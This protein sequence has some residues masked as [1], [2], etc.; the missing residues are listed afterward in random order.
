MRSS[1]Y[2]VRAG[3][4]ALAMTAIIAGRVAAM[5]P[6]EFRAS[7]LWATAH[8]SIATYI[9]FK[10]DVWECAKGTE[11]PDLFNPTTL[12]VDGYLDWV[13][14]IGAQGFLIT[15]MHVDGFCLWPS[16]SSPHNISASAWYREHG[17]RNVLREFLDGARKRGLRV[18]LYFSMQDRYFEAH[19]D[20]N[21]KSYTAAV[22][23]HLRELLGGDYGQID[24]LVLDAWP[25]LDAANYTNLPYD[26]IYPLIKKLQPNC[27]V[28]INHH[29]HDG[30]HGDVD[31][32]EQPAKIDGEPPPGRTTFP[33]VLCWSTLHQDGVWFGHS[34]L[35][36]H[37]ISQAEVIRARTERMT[38]AGY[39]SLV[40][41]SPGPSGA[42]ADDVQR[43][44]GKLAA[45]GESAKR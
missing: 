4:V 5:T 14:K 12:D 43:V 35:T 42:L 32:F 29:E 7:R 45:E 23:A 30:A 6:A 26:S 31:V 11:S 34:D 21:P 1:S 38:A 28:G 37:A 22:Q 9:S 40:N 19:H 13:Q 20:V 3:A 24:L 44:L 18:G 2:L 39:I 17:R 36:P 10:A 41:F 16:A 33:S 25:W 15:A 8:F 27:L